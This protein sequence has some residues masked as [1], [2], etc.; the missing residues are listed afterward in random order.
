MSLSFPCMQVEVLDDSSDEH[1][2]QNKL[3]IN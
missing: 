3:R 2:Q 1:D